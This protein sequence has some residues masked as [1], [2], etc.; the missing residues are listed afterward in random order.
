MAGPESQK[1]LPPTAQAAPTSVPAAPAVPISSAA[2]SEP[3]SVGP[4]KPSGPSAVKSGEREQ[5]PKG[6]PGFRDIPMCVIPEQ[7]P[8]LVDN[9]KPKSPVVDVT[10][11]EPPA[12]LSGE[13][14]AVATWWKDLPSD[15]RDK[16][17]K[18]RPEWVGNIDGIAATDRDRANRSQIP[19]ERAR[20]ER[21]R[22]QLQRNLD[23]NW[24]GGTFTNDDAKKWY[25]EEKLKDLD[26]VEST[27]AKG[28][29]DAPRLLL[30]L[31]MRSGERG[32]AAVAVGNPDTA[33]HVAVTTPGLGTTISGALDGGRPSDGMV[34]EAQ[35]LRA[36]TSRQLDL[37]GR[38]DETV[39]TIAWLG[40]DA[41]NMTGPGKLDTVRGGGDVASTGKANEAAPRLANFFNGLDAASVKKDPH[42]VAYGHS[43]GSLVTAEA[44]RK[45]RGSVDEAVFYGSPGLGGDPNDLPRYEAKHFNLT[46][47]RMYLLENGEDLVA[48]FGH[49]GPDPSVAGGFTRLSTHPG[50]D[51]TNVP[52]IGGTGHSDYL[53]VG[54][55]P[56]GQTPE[57]R[58]A[59][60]NMAAVL[61][62]LPDNLIE[63]D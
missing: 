54:Y 43:Y 60:Y 12:E 36:E 13:P 7:K 51:R 28:T 2:G 16:I 6:T 35:Q 34:G 48:D 44:L 63:G 14:D 49:F 45:T 56:D 10:A 58:M 61:G 18:E 29:P 30:L 62:S 15:E 59:G 46:S 39:S 25:V 4:E 20:L 23:D 37:A 5:A 33:D 1:T 17:V 22:D 21:E 26:T 55:G 24:F 47:D 27:L 19:I 53:R 40:Y 57:M 8:T 11:S 32:H 38:P 3:P 41:P 42:I 52:R 50:V 31:D 9:P